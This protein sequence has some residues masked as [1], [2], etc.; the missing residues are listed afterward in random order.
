MPKTKKNNNNPANL[1]LD[2]VPTIVMVAGVGGLTAVVIH[3]RNESNKSMNKAATF[4]TDKIFGT[5]E[6]QAKLA[7]IRGD[8]Y[9][10][11]TPAYVAN[12]FYE[13]IGLDPAASLGL[14][15]ISPPDWEAIIHGCGIWY[16]ITCLLK[17]LLKHID[18]CLVMNY[19]LN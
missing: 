9:Q 4:A 18:C 8:L 19:C 16:P 11:D 2:N 17:T 15:G 3:R 10:P 7:T 14:W 5:E 6:E 1:V 13:N 12:M